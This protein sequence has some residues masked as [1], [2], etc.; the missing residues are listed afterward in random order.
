VQGP[1][2]PAG[3]TPGVAHAPAPLRTVARHGWRAAQ[4]AARGRATQIWNLQAFS[5]LRAC[6][7]DPCSCAP[8]VEFPASATIWMPSERRRPSTSILV[9]ISG[10]VRALM[11]DHV[12]TFTIV[13]AQYTEAHRSPPVAQLSGNWDDRPIETGKHY[14]NSRRWTRR[15]GHSRHW[16]CVRGSRLSRCR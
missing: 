1:G 3:R 12:W 16:K 6:G 9:R 11:S 14:G 5:R 13:V 4:N 8:G 7:R 10:V 15:T 2:R